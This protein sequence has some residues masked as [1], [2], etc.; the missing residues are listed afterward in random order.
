MV[1]TDHSS[2]AVTP[3]GQSPRRCLV[4]ASSRGRRRYPQAVDQQ[5]SPCRAST[6]YWRWHTT[7]QLTQWQQQQCA[8]TRRT[9]NTAATDPLQGSHRSSSVEGSSRFGASCPRSADTGRPRIAVCSRPTTARINQSLLQQL[10]AWSHGSRSSRAAAPSQP[11]AP[12]CSPACLWL[13]P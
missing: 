3:L 9:P 6:D 5:E 2:A 10:T 13:L 4:K 7:T 1:R 11:S 8:L 12:P